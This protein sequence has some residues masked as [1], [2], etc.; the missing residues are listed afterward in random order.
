MK[1]K[2]NKK[3]KQAR[4][5]INHDKVRMRFISLEYYGMYLKD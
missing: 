4:E 2:R 5:S 3:K 1:I